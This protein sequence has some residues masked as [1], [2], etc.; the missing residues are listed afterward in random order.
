MTLLTVMTTIAWLACDNAF[1]STPSAA[2]TPVTVPTP[3][4]TPFPEVFAI[5][6][7]RTYTTNSA[8]AQRDYAGQ[9]Y[10]VSGVLA[11]ISTDT[12]GNHDVKLIGDPSGSLGLA[13]GNVSSTVV[14]KVDPRDDS[15]IDNIAQYDIGQQAKVT[16]V[17]REIVYVD[18]VIWP[19]AVA[20]PASPTTTPT[21]APMSSFIPTPAPAPEP[22]PAPSV[23]ATIRLLATAAPTPTP[24]PP[25]ATPELTPEPP[26]VTPELTPEPPPATPEPTPS[27]P[28]ATPEP[29]PAPPPATP[30]PTPA[31][32]P[33]TPEPTP[34]PPPATPEPTQEPPALV[35]GTNLGNL[36]P[37]FQLP[38]ASGSDRS[39]ASYR[40]DKHV[41]V[42]FYRAFW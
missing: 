9:T 5:N 21:S 16:G 26:P 31:P 34:A 11:T 40:G 36:S 41:V 4:A 15:S 17:I 29:T 42:V 24:T 28:P 37:D 2:T 33:A 3:G 23:P 32:P 18:L 6:L 22:P 12:D 1:I 30:E 19:C 20:S 35:V 25:A 38:A 39:L 7:Y 8:K 13:W 14:C 10:V 27:H